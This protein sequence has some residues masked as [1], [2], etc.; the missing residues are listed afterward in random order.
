MN[1]H[2][3]N[4]LTRT[5][6]IFV[7]IDER[8]V[9]LYACGPTVYD[10]AHIGNARPAVVFDVLFRLLRHRYG[11]NCVIYV[12]NI[13]DI[14]DKI[15][16]KARSDKEQG[17]T[18]PLLEIIGKITD[19]TI[20]W[21][22]EDLDELNVLRPTHEPR[23]TEFIPKMISMIQSLID[24]GH[25]Y[26]AEG[27]VLF[28]VE[29][30]PNYGNLARRSL[31]DMIAGARV[32]QAPYKQ[33]PMDFVMWKPS[34]ENLPGWSSPW[35][36]GRPGWHIECSAMSL[37]LLGSSFDIHAGGIDLAFPHHENELAQSMCA[38]PNC[39]FAN[40]WMHNGFLQVEGKKMA[41]SLGNFFT[42]KDLR[43]QGISGEVMRL[44]LLSTHYRQPI[45]WTKRKV[46]EFN[47]ILTNWRN[48]ALRV[49]SAA[50]PNQRVLEAIADDL[51][52]PKAISEMHRL[53]NSGDIEGLKASAEFLGINLDLS[54][55]SV[56]PIIEKL[57]KI[58]SE[59]R[60]NRDFVLADDVRNKLNSLGI[61]I[62]DGAEGT[63]WSIGSSFELDQIS[64]LAKEF[65]LGI[66]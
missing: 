4:T 30:Y 48:L 35:G 27:H 64:N 38:N 9:R 46:G 47:S 43:D 33:N 25:A 44:V 6:E 2:F 65:D 28:S 17:D 40:V 3:Y 10:R 8:H 31:D 49:K 53:A 45:D 26:F 58:R 51:N 34:S 52:T 57:L 55:D 20:S 15:N 19:Q 29:S 16:E 63:S 60:Q 61:T 11:K 21:Y 12:R 56:A 14:D 59:A 50:I 22:H 24:K 62:N 7:P 5:K 41:K 1:L 13:T 37:D 39:K 66:E 32:E 23:A 36:R 54:L 42:V 18:S